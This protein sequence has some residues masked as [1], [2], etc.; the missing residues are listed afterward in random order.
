MR[1][2]L[3]H[4]HYLKVQ[5]HHT[6]MCVSGSTQAWGA[7]IHFT[8]CVLTLVLLSPKSKRQYWLHIYWRHGLHLFHRELLLNRS[9]LSGRAKTLSCAPANWHCEVITD[10]VQEV[11][12]F[13]PGCVVLQRVVGYKPSGFSVEQNSKEI[14]CFSSLCHYVSKFPLSFQCART[15]TVTVKPSF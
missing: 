4:L 11:C 7:S 14:A 6:E 2:H 12:P 5:Y 9:W 15:K 3:T 1:L 8:V 10:E 13:V